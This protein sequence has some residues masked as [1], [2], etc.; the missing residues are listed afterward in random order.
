L[1][2]IGDY[3]YESLAEIDEKSHI[4]EGSTSKSGKSLNEKCNPSKFV[5]FNKLQQQ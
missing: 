4:M 2:V 5:I 3:A 1:F